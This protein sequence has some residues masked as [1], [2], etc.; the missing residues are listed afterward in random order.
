MIRR[1]IRFFWRRLSK[2][3]A[4]TSL[5]VFGLTLGFT[6]FIAIM[7]YVL[8]E[9]S[10]DGFNENADRIFRINTD[11]KFGDNETSQA[12]AAPPVAD[13]LKTN[14][15]EVENVVRIM[16][17]HVRLKTE[18]QL[19]IWEEKF[20]YCDPG[21]FEI[22]TLP[23]IQGNFNTA[24]RTPNSLVLSKSAALKYF[25]TVNVVGKTLQVI[26][27]GT[28]GTKTITGIIRDV[29]DNSHFRADVFCTMLDVPLS[30]N[31][32][33]A[34][35]YPFNTYVL[36]KHG[37]N[38]HTL[39]VK[40]SKLLN[41]YLPIDEI[42]KNG[43][44]FRISFTSLKDIHLKSHRQRELG[45]NGSLMTVNI[46]FVVAILILLIA[47]VNC[48]NLS[49]STAT[50]KA[51]EVAV[52]KVLGS[53][54][55]QLFL[56]LISEAVV[57]VLTAILISSVV[58]VFLS[59]SAFFQ[60]LTGLSGGADFSL[61]VKLATVT[62]FA[63]LLAVMCAGAYPAMLI[64]GFNPKEVFHGK[65][66]SNYKHSSFRNILVVGQF[67][68]SIFLL[69]S[70]AVVYK[71]FSFIHKMDIGY[72]R[73]MVLMVK[74]VNVL[75]N[76]GV[77]LKQEVKKML[78]VMDASLSSFVPTG[79]RRWINYLSSD[80][81][82]IETQFWPVDE[83]YVN[84]MGMKMIE[85]RNFSSQL[86]NDSSAII[87]NETAASQLGIRKDP[88]QKRIYYGDRSKVYH[89]VGVVK[90]F[91]FNSLKD[92]VTPVFLT[93]SSSFEKSEQGDEPGILSIRMSADNLSARIER[94]RKLWNGFA[95][96][97]SFSY[98]FMNDQFDAIYKEEKQGSILITIFSS[99]A[100]TLGCLGLFGLCAISA[101]QRRK[102]LGI[103]KVLGA[104]VS[105]IV[106]LISRDFI[107]LVII[108]T[109]ISVPLSVMAMRF[110][111]QNF[112]YH[113]TIGYTPVVSGVVIALLV[114]ALTVCAQAI[115]AAMA[116]PV[117]NLRSE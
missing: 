108:A 94:I 48:M 52:R 57:P 79:K 25:G 101:N 78:G 77:L 11:T 59:S 6:G 92:P 39:E 2:N 47:C 33:F 95:P 68:I 100:I 64:S 22:F 65:L 70:T 10:F 63:F 87:I 74:N 49:L 55:S 45:I 51:K 20:V 69:I 23:M 97:E 43:D 72:D 113:T 29:P 117:K 115:K 105:S 111:L 76:R 28:P 18:G 67:C 42:E 90:D 3:I 35:L 14:F 106:V 36:L 27:G 61:L 37:V 103:R 83:D 84:T 24:L 38:A 40:F 80:D 8:H 58:V 21:I 82:I 19:S 66:L 54:R 75:G 7:L 89:V 12:I 15:S 114:A 46:F 13:A 60:Q 93:M 9:K 88:L 81:K 53:N 50:F 16:Q 26:D 71:Q 34:A 116:N 107:L 4:F 112:A 102:E 99:L 98:S 5:N 85:G 104:G 41:T 44:Y 56:Q 1:C 30:N 109:A 73:N 31:Q 96:Q 62:F 86:A 32:N 110:W 91:N 17:S